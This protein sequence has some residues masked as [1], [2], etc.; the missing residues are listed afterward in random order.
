MTKEIN[1][2]KL[3]RAISLLAVLQDSVKDAKEHRDLSESHVGLFH[4]RLSDI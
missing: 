3:I 4:A 2:D 1:V